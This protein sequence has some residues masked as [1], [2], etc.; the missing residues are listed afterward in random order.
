MKKTYSFIVSTIVTGLGS[1]LSPFSPGTCGSI[2]SLI[3]W[4]IVVQCMPDSLVLPFTL[5]GAGI[6]TVVGII[7]SSA[8]IEIHKS[9]PGKDGKIDP[10]CI[11]IDEW[12]G[13]WIT[14]LGT[15]H[16]NW[17]SA[18]LALALFRIFDISKPWLVRRAEYLPGGYGIMM[19]DVVAGIFALIARI[20]VETYLPF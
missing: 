16:D 13:M 9:V 14:L 8:Y 18:L 1:G 4:G 10:Q 5:L 20:L 2:A 15:A 12:A 7:A 6:F 17:H 3:V 11:V 19:D